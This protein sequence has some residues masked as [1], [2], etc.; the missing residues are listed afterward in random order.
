VVEAADDIGGRTRTDRSLGFAFDL[1]ASWIHGTDGN[2]ITDL[3]D[4]AGAP[5]TELDFDDVT[6]F[7][8]DGRERTAEEFEA[9]EAAFESLLETVLEEGDDDRSF[10][11]VVADEEPD[12]FD[13]RL[14]AFFTSTYLAFD[15]GDLDRL[16]STLRDE[17]D[18]FDGPE[19]MMTDG[20]DRVAAHLA[21]GLDI[22]TSQVVT[23]VE[24]TDDRVIVSVGDTTITAAHAVIAV[25][26]G[27]LQARAITFDP[28]L[29]DQ[30]LAAIDGIGFNAVEK[31]LFVWEDTFWDDSDFLVY[32]PTRRDVCNWFV[33]VNALVDGS[34]ALMTFAYAD[35]AR[36]AATAT[37]ATMT[38][39]AMTHLRAMYGADVPEPIAMRRSRWVG[40]PFTRGGYSYTAITTSMEHFD[41]VATPVGRLHF[42]GEH[43]HRDCFSTTHGAHLSGRRAAAEIIG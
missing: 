26:L 29:P 18:E 8:E 39:L 43:T 12:W 20:Y 42:A 34:H 22:R 19:V 4:A 6:V 10:A 7:D 36:A 21:T 13:D 27:V 40:D 32:T 14:Q 24:A 9:A 16:S 31:F 17:G 15:T 35:E 5:T 30:H 38:A 23:A 2:P 25:P 28:P 3:A 33:N 37:D 1:G 11:D 41:T